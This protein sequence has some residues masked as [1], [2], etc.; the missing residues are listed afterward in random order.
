MHRSKNG[1]VRLADRPA[2]YERL[3][4]D[5][6]QIAQ[7]EDGQRIGTEKGLYEWWYFDAHLDDGATVVVVFYTKPNVSPSGPLAPRVTINITLPDGRIYDKLLDTTPEMFTASKSTCNVKIGTNH[8]VGD[9]NRYHITATIGEISVD[10]ELTGDVP[11]WRPKSGHSY[12]GVEGREKLFAWLPAVPHGLANVRYS[13]G[14]EEYGA[15]GSGY[16]DHNWGDV[17]MQTL[18]HNWY[19]AR[20]S[21]GPYTVIASYITATEAYGYET[22]IVYMLARDGKIIADDDAKVSFEMDRVVID[23]KTGKPVADVTRYTY[24]DADTRYVVSFER[25]ETILQAIFTERMPLLKRIVARLIGFDGAYH[26]FTGKVTIERFEG[27][28][29]VEHFDDRAIW[30]LM[31]FGKARPGV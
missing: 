27:D 3:G 6:V 15:S 25:E 20:A 7:F 8:F 29:R 9:L 11:A 1:H 23:G 17:P 26:R 2:D 24:R 31:Y 28:A 13:I 4:I 30:E 10:I 12:F 16:H 14:K 19:W 21:V 18:M 5:P 22:Q